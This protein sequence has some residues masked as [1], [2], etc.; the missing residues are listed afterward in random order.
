MRT[1]EQMD[2]LFRQLCRTVREQVTLV[3]R[4]PEAET[5]MECALRFA[6]AAA[7]PSAVLGENCSPFALGFVAASGAGGWASGCGLRAGGTRSPPV[8]AR[9]AV[10]YAES[11]KAVGLAQSGMALVACSS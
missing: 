7:L 9:R 4:R 8:P 5:V 2:G 6:V 3:L 1:I 10:P 11:H